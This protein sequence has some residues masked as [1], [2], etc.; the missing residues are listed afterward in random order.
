MP[1]K[2]LCFLSPRRHGSTYFTECPSP[3][4]AVGYFKAIEDLCVIIRTLP[5]LLLAFLI[6]LLARSSLVTYLESNEHFLFSL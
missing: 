5:P 6:E 1:R 3:E 2:Q 4:E